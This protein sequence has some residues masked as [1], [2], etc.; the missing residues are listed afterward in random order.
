MLETI[1]SKIEETN[2][3]E[4]TNDKEKINT[5]IRRVIVAEIWIKEINTPIVKIS[6]REI[7]NSKKKDQ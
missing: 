4:K 7:R 3:K 5:Q 2:F 1:E 6:L